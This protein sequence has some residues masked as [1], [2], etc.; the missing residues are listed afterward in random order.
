MCLL[1]HEGVLPIGWV[2]S[3]SDGRWFIFDIRLIVFPPLNFRQI[4]DLRMS[5]LLP[6]HYRSRRDSRLYALPWRGRLSRR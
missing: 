2:I 4:L 3:G 5:L 6:C 1:P